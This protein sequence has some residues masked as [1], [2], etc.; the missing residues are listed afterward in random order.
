MSTAPPPVRGTASP[1]APPPNWADL[2]VAAQLEGSADSSGKVTLKAGKWQPD[3]SW[4]IWFNQVFQTQQ[5][6]LTALG[7]DVF[8]VQ[9]QPVAAPGD[10][11]AAFAQPVSGDAAAVTALQNALATSARVD[12]WGDRIADLERQLAFKQVAPPVVPQIIICTQATFPLLN[13]GN[14]GSFIYVTDY[15]HWIYWDG[16][17]PVFAD[18][19]SDYYTVANAAPSAIGWH[20]VDGSVVN[21]LNADGTLTSKT[22]VNVAGT[23][24]YL[25]VGP[26]TDTLNSPVAPTF[27]GTPATPAGS[28]TSTFT[29]TP[30]TW[31]VVDVVSLLGTQSVLE[32]D[33]T[34]NPYTPA[35]T[36]VSSFAGTPATPAGTISNTAEPENFYSKLWFRL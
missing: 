33:A 2:V 29:G 7:L 35:G 28:V 32:D 26:G 27:T 36:V 16:T 17:T 1:I 31:D 4:A 25:K 5:L 11:S 20:A 10:A 23:P 6:V 15:A 3:I 13:A 30:K 22:L 12:S 8:T 24:A 19:G 21:Y 14:K 18:G 34:N 9:A